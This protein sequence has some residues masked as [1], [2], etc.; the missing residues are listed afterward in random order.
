ML[1]IVD[2]SNL[3]RNLYLVSQV[4]DIGMPVVVALNMVD[5]ADRQQI[6]IDTERLSD[7]LGVPVIPVQAH[8]RQGLSQLKDA[9]CQTTAAA[10]SRCDTG[11]AGS[12]VSRGRSD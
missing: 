12:S 8:R 11:H 1:C 7:R 10:I 6:R 5:L 4:L 2:A 9:L 3:Q